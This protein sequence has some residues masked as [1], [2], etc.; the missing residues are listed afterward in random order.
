MPAST[1]TLKPIVESV[2]PFFRPKSALAVL[3]SLCWFSNYFGGMVS[4]LLS[5]YLPDAVLDLVGRLEEAAL[6][7]IGSYVGALYLIGWALGGV[8]FGYLGDQIGRVRA[9]AGTFLLYA[10]FTLAASFVKSWQLLVACRLLAGFGVGGTL[11]VSAVLVAEVWPDRTR[12]VALGVLA[13]G[14]PIGIMSA[15]IVNYLVADWRTAFLL[16]AVPLGLALLAAL[17]LREPGRT[18]SAAAAGTADPVGAGRFVQLF[19]P[20]HRATF[21]VGATIFGSMLVGIWAVF[22]WLPTWAQSLIGMDQDGQQQR[23]LLMMLLGGGGIIGGIVGGFLANALGRRRSLLI[24]FAGA[25]AASFLL[26]KTNDA[27]SS[28]I[29]AETAFLAVFFGIS[30]GILTAYVPELFPAAIRSTAT[31]VCFNAGRVVT[32]GAV[33][34]VGVLVPVLGG[35]GNAVFVFSLT[36]VLGFVAALFGK[37]TKG[38]ALR[39]L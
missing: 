32:A 9:F 1:P 38:I 15:G 27:F 23:G 3:F 7:E 25:F 14:F 6:S 22:S 19:R 30:Q 8:T 34:F 18:L 11:V 13:V 31:G 33:F 12:A 20:P 37:E 28:I 35:Y 2:S 10:V 29:Y 39:E 17:V 26:F 16:S 5:A 21:L 4:T 24:A 36:Y